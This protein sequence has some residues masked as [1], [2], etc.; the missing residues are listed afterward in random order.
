[1]HTVDSII[2]STPSGPADYEFDELRFNH[3]ED[4]SCGNVIKR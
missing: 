4:G 1:M 2:E 3:N